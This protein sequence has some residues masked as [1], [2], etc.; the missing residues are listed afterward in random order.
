M[1][2][3]SPYIMDIGALGRNQELGF[4]RAVIENCSVKDSVYMSQKDED[5]VHIGPLI[6]SPIFA[7]E[8]LKS[9][10]FI[11]YI[12]AFTFYAICNKTNKFQGKLNLPRCK[13]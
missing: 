5:S 11:V 3:K 8:T 6:L 12:G 4:S 2:Q 1:M 13:G 9:R 7:F 10:R